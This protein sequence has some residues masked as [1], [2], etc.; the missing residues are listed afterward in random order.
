MS[1]GAFAFFAITLGTVSIAL[2]ALLSQNNRDSEIRIILIN[3]TDARC[4]DL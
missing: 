4:G 1:D 2:A 3:I